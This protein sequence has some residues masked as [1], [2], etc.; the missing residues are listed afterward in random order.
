MGYTSEMLLGLILLK[1]LL[2]RDE[3]QSHN[4]VIFADKAFLWPTTDYKG[5][6]AFFMKTGYSEQQSGGP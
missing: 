4:Q 5:V 6:T 1:C 2:L 3:Q